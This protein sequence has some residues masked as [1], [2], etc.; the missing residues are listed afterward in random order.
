MSCRKA[1]DHADETR[2]TVL[3][4]KNWSV[5]TGNINVNRR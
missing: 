4:A 5:K 2:A 3:I 1:V